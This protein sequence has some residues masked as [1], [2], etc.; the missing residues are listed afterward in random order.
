[1]DKNQGYL[2]Y[3]MT[4]REVS[5][6]I[7]FGGNNMNYEL[8][9]KKIAGLPR[10]KLAFLP[11]PLE[12]LE[13]F[14]KM[15]KL[16]IYIKRDD[17]TGLAFGGNKARKL[18]FI[19]AD[20]INNK[21]DTI[22]TWGGIQS[23]WCRQ[24]AAAAKKMD[25]KPVLILFKK[26]HFPPECDGN[27]FL[28][29]VF[30]SDI[31]LIELESGHET[32][33]LKDIQDIVDK[34]V[35]HEKQQGN[36]PYLV[37]GGGSLVEGSMGTPLGVIS[38]VDA[39]LEIFMQINTQKIHLDKILVAAAS[40]STLAG[41]IVGAKLLMPETKIIG[42]SVMKDKAIMTKYVMSM[43]NDALKELDVNI[44]ITSE[45]II[46][47]DEYIKE[48]YGV[49]NDDVNEAI[50]L[51]AQSEGILL[52]P[53]YTGKNMVG[54]LDLLRKGFFKPDENVLFM[55]TGG[56]PALFAYKDKLI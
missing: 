29:T 53:V 28:D 23:N 3:L 51:L 34:V 15:F 26:P 30:N 18:E 7:S 6:K 38:Y 40:G 55:H 16:S 11:T 4:L 36:N 8:L 20:V 49:V 27:Y 48:G 13:K 54:L 45:D 43:A 12:K 33:E 42:I 21:A 24:V 39:F 47:Y 14:S 22:V 5:T 31:K 32:F 17:Q 35:A 44:N 41:L 56:T 2:F 52:D 1:M 46:I 37:S 19:M 50:H 25:I 10:V 9:Q